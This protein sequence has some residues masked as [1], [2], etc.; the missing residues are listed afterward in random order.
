M[1]EVNMQSDNETDNIFHHLPEDIDINDNEVEKVPTMDVDV[2]SFLDEFFVAKMTVVS[3]ERENAELKGKIDSLLRW[4]EQI[5]RV[6]I[7]DTINNISE[8]KDRK[9]RQRTDEQVCF[10]NFC[11]TYKNDALILA[12]VSTK[13]ASLGY[14]GCKKVPWSILKL[15]LR[16]MYENLSKDDKIKYLNKARGT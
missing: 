11:E 1:S 15:E 3:L 9:H 13:F 12:R 7:D 6:M 8:K 10:L 14:G 4:K 5:E 2:D 16:T